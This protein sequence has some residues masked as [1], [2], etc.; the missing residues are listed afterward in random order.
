MN[1][2]HHNLLPRLENALAF[3]EEQLRKLIEAHPDFYP[4]YT[5]KGRWKHS[6]E[7][8]TNWCEGFL[9]GILWILHQLTGWR[10]WW[11]KAEHY[12]ALLEHRKSDRNVHDLG[13]VFMSSYGRWYERTHDPDLR[14]VLI[15][16]GQTLALRFQR[17]GKY[18]CS[19]VAPESLFIDIMMNVGIIFWAAEKTGDAALNELATTH[20][21]TT[22]KFLVHP[23]GSTVHEGLFDL[24]TGQFIKESTHQGYQPDSCWSRGLSWALYGFGTAYQFT[25]NHSFLETAE[26]CADYYLRHVPSNLVPYWDFQVPE[27]PARLWDSSAGAIA[28]SGLWNLSALTHSKVKAQL[29]RQSAFKIM[30]TLVSEEFLAQGEKDQQGVLL[31][32]VYHYHKKLGVDESVMWGEY[33]FMEALE[34]T[35]IAL[36]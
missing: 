9:P 17:K 18:L 20:C 14:E 15:E 34:K 1:S 31:H 26:R 2:H 33:F 30:S 27:G 24:Q 36:R 32:G 35:L 21:Q 12:S 11:D 7:A 13:F 25:K 28:A 3:A 4:M 8:W 19:F 10:Y 29:Y 6:G 16:A 23:D 5:E 22:Q